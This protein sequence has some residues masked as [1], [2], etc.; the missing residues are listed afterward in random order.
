LRGRGSAKGKLA[1]KNQKRPG[2]KKRNWA[3]FGEKN[4]L[5]KRERKNRER[6]L[7]I[8]GSSRLR[9]VNENV[10]CR[11]K[12]EDGGEACYR[13]GTGVQTKEGKKGGIGRESLLKWARGRGGSRKVW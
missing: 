12:S 10:R 2:S 9:K 11:G 8:K 5:K 7:R 6:G 1:L 13:K 4:R 3:H